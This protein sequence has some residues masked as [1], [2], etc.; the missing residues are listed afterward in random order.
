MFEPNIDK[1]IQH[2]ENEFSQQILVARQKY[3]QYKKELNDLYNDLP[4]YLKE[5]VDSELNKNP[6][7]LIKD[8]PQ[9]LV[10]ATEG[11][12]LA[13]TFASFAEFQ[14]YLN[15]PIDVAKKLKNPKGMTPFIINI[16]ID[17]A[18]EY[19]E[20]NSPRIIKA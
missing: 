3:E 15:N 11:I 14:Q 7:W 18:T 1:A 16:A 8:L 13:K 5:R 17:I 9:Y 20:R 10:G 4:D 6:S 2:A 19:L 12:Y